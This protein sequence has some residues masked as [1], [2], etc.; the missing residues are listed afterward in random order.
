MSNYHLR[1]KVN[2]QSPVFARLILE[3]FLFSFHAALNILVVLSLGA[4]LY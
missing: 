3:L 1:V 2:V 4:A